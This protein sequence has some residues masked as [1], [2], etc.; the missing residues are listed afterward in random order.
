MG[1]PVSIEDIILD[2]DRRGIA[3]LRPHMAPDFC[4]QAAALVLEHP[5]T[6]LIATGFYI[7]SAG[8]AETDGPP[9]AVAIGEALQRLGYDVAY[10]TDQ[11]TYPVMNDLAGSRARVVDFPIADEADSARFSDR[12]LEEVGPSLLVSI[13]RCGPSE[14]GLYRNMRDLDITSYTARID[15]LFADHP[16]TVGIGDGGNEI[17]MGVLASVVPTVPTLVRLPCVTTTTKLVLSSVSNWGGYGLVA[18]MS[19]AKGVNLLPS[20]EAEQEM[21]R[22]CADLGAVDSMSSRPEAR[23]DGFTLEE[24]SQ[25]LVKLHELLARD[26]ISH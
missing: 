11:Y 21:V 15:R 25:T 14:D 3:A 6:A 19:I 10:V 24:N 4:D 26:G 12:L 1:W 7:L 16:H 8:A 9:G 13:E 23:V 5:G 17:G 20:V 18:A 22:C 2:H